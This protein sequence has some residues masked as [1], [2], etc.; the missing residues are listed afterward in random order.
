MIYKKAL[1]TGANG[2]IGRTIARRLQAEGIEVVGVDSHTGGQPGMIAGDIATPGTWQDAFS[3]CD[4]VI[5]TAAVVS[6]AVDAETT[7]RVNVLGTRHVVDAAI[8]AG[9]TRLIHLSS[10]RAFSDVN[11][12]DGVDE[13][14]PVRTDGNAYVDTKIASEHVALQAHAAGEL[15]VT[16]IRPGDVY[17]PGSRPWVVLPIEAMKSGSF[18]LPADG[19]G[20]F[21]PVYVDDLIDGLLLAARHPK[22][23]GQ[24]FTLSGP[25]TCTTSE[26]F[27]YLHRMLGRSG[28]PKTVP[29][30]LA[31]GA[32]AVVAFVARLRG[33]D[34]EINPTTIR[35]LART[36]GYSSKKAEQLINYRPS[37]S[38]EQGMHRTGVWL[39]SEGLL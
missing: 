25:E 22:A 39:R 12:P 13:Q 33:V 24:I 4:L 11:F 37:V 27:G 6:N 15:A 1:I 3:G 34:T 9:V 2:F 16:I 32:A 7:W 17:G 29:T 21:S 14:W 35:Y 31:L 38:L 23:A 20:I 19:K 18:A 8:K 30:S 5:H 26:Y 10:V 28:S 36:G